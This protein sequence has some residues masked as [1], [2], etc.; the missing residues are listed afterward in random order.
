MV[1]KINLETRQYVQHFVLFS[2]L[3]G[4]YFEGS[5]LKKTWCPQIVLSPRA[6]RCHTKL[7][8]FLELLTG[9]IAYNF[10]PV[11]QYCR[12]L[13][14]VNKKFWPD[15]GFFLWKHNCVQNI[16]WKAMILAVANG[17]DSIL[18]RWWGQ[19]GGLYIVLFLWNKSLYTWLKYSL[20]DLQ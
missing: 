12:E 3:S 7:N 2:I 15:V 4:F 18:E 19:V 16:T 20:N 6:M 14:E 1:K 9:T 10:S 8:K 11:Y 5:S 17:R 13:F